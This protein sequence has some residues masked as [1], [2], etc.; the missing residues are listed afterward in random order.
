MTIIQEASVQKPFINRSSKILVLGQNPGKR[1]VRQKC[2]H[3]FNFVSSRNGSLHCIAAQPWARKIVEQ[4]KKLDGKYPNIMNIANCV[5]ENNDISFRHVEMF[6][7]FNVV[8]VVD[9]VEVVLAF[10]LGAKTA[11]FFVSLYLKYGQ[12]NISDIMIV[13]LRHPAWVAR[14][15]R[16]DFAL[17]S[18]QLDIIARAIY[19]TE[20]RR[21]YE[22]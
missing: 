2:Q 8:Q 15:R 14:Y 22:K 3:P 19:K 9:D 4:I 6:G 10:C 1:Q 13:E 7:G 5:T 20:Q 16:N 17:Q 12:R 21:T 18:D 11:G